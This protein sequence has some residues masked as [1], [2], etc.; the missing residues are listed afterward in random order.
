M[1]RV[2]LLC[3]LTHLV[4]LSAGAQKPDVDSLYARHPITK[5]AF[6]A[7][8]YEWHNGYY[9]AIADVR[10]HQP[11]ITFYI[12]TRAKKAAQEAL[13]YKRTNFLAEWHVVTG[14]PDEADVYANANKQINKP[15]QPEE[16]QKGHCQPWILLAWCLEAC[17]LSDTYTFNAGM[18]YRGQ[19]TGTQEA[20]EDFS[21]D[22]LNKTDGVSI[23]CGT[24]GNLHIWADKKDKVTDT[25]PAYYW[26]LIEAGG[27]TYCWLMPNQPSEKYDLLSSRTI[28]FN[29]LAAKLGYNPKSILHSL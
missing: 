12:Y 29:D 24:F 4:V 20:S 2:L 21:R 7:D 16:L 27:Q 11:V 9:G 14:M 5:S 22:L 10:L 3:C 17:V 15:R 26:K 6:C 8:C 25:M 1:R 19:N 28:S 13:G 18:E 23:W